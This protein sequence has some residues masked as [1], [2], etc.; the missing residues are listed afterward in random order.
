[1]EIKGA[2]QF[3]KIDSA[4]AR[5]KMMDADGLIIKTVEVERIIFPAD[6]EQPRFKVEGSYSFTIEITDT[7]AKAKKK[8]K[9][10]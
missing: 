2:L 5:L 1:M 3:D 9:K 4:K 10:K 8:K 7:F 6:F